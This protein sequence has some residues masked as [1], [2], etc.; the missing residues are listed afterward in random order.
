[1]LARIVQIIDSFDAATSSRRIYRRPLAPDEA[2][3][4]ILKGAG[5]IYDPPLA[6]A[7]VHEL[8]VYPVGTIVVLDD[9]GLA[10]VRRP[11][12]RDAARPVIGLIDPRGTTPSIVHELNLEEHRE[13]HIVRSV[14]PADL[15]MDVNTYMSLAS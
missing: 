13:R 5:T 7:F 3:R 9:G 8:G 14:D 15:G 2:M 6:K 11:G 10:V 1:M 4:F 12:Q